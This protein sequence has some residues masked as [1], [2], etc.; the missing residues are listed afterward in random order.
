ME[1]LA[2]YLRGQRI[3]QSYRDLN[4]RCRNYVLVARKDMLRI[5]YSFYPVLRDM[6]VASVRKSIIEELKE[7]EG[8]GKANDIEFSKA[9]LYFRSFR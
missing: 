1:T 5:A 8:E 4:L 6:G 2:S 3:W 9:H 7:R